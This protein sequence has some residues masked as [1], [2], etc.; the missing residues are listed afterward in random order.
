LDAS[1][2]ANRTPPRDIF[3]SAVILAAGRAQRMGFS[4]LN[5]QLSGKSLLRHVVDVA[6]AS[7]VSEV[8]VVLGDHAEELAPEIP[9]DRRLRVVHN[10]R[11]AEGQTTSLQAGLASVHPDSE[12]VVVFLGDQ[13]LVSPEA[14]NALVAEFSLAGSPIVMPLYQGRKGHPILFAR[15]LF[16]EL[17]ALSPDQ[18]RRDVV[19]RHLGEA[20]TVSL[21]ELIA[22]QDVDTWDDYLKMKQGV[23]DGTL[24]TDSSPTK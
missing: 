10:P 19:T 7:V 8:V 2:H 14:V 20:A 6:L 16:S 18:P 12:A 1:T 24:T 11:F 17:L 4:K 21:D 9:E 3:V 22:P 23:E 13:P 15:S 5:L